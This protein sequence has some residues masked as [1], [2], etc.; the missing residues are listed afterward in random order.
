MRIKYVTTI[1][2]RF[3]RLVSVGP[4]PVRKYG[5]SC[6]I[7]QCDCGSVVISRPRDVVIGHQKSCGCLHAEAIGH[8]AAS[9][10][11]AKGYTR[12][13]TYLCWHNMR[14][15]C[16]YAPHPQYM[17]YGGRGITVCQRWQ[18]FE[19][20]L[21]DMGERPRRGL[22][23]ERRDNDRGYEP[24]NCEWATRATQSRNKRTNRFVQFNGLNLCATDWAK[25]IGIN[26]NTL[27]RRL[28][29]WPIE[30]A[31]TA[32]STRKKREAT[33]SARHKNGGELPV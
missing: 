9:H 11:H 26:A 16:E 33:P 28:R 17:A 2:Q 14:R 20:F 19:N 8:R 1:G 18:V 12:T 25:K 23:L 3:G 7:F 13:P 30:R 31:L 27:I 15:R 5:T 4:T 32:P 24:G 22:S 10:G 21:A 6:W 29:V